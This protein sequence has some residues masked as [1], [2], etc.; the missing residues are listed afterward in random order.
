MKTRIL[1]AVL[2]SLLVVSVVSAAMPN[3]PAGRQLARVTPS[4]V[5]VAVPEQVVESSP[6]IEPVNSSGTHPT[7]VI[8]PTTSAIDKRNFRAKGCTILHELSD[9]TALACPK[10]VVIPG[11]RPDRLFSLHDL[12]AD[13]QIGADLVWAEG[14]YDGTGVLVAILDTGVDESHIELS[15]SIVATKNFV[16][17]RGVDKDG[18]GTHVS[19]IVTANG[20]YEIEGNYATGVA[21]GAA[22]IV[23]KVC[24]P[25]G[26]YESDIMAGIEWAV[27]QGASVLNL[28]IGGGNFCGE[29]CD[30]DPLA[31]KVNWAVSEGV[32][33]AISAGNEGDCVSSPACAS[34]A[35]AVGAT[36][37][38]DYAQDIDWVDCIDAAPQTDDRVCWS[39][40]GPALDLVAPGI[41][42]LSTYSCLA[43]GDCGSYWYAW[44][45]GTSMSAPHIAGTAALILQKNPGYTVQDVKNAF[46]STAVDLG[47]VGYDSLYGWG[48]VDAY[49]AVQWTAGPVDNPPTVNITAPL[50]GATVSGIVTISAEAADD[51]GVVQVDFYCDSILLETDTTSTYSI[52]WDSSAVSDGPHSL[53][54]TAIDTAA[55]T[56]SDS[57]SVTVDNYNDP[58]VADDQSV[59]TVEDTSVD[60]TL[61]AGDADGDSLTFTIVAD[62]CNGILTGSAPNVTYT[63]DPGFTGSDSFTFRAYD[64]QAYSNIATV[65]I[66]VNPAGPTMHVSDITIG[67]RKMGRN[68]QATAYVTVVDEFGSP[69]GGA[70]VTG[71]WTL[72]GGYLN[73]ASKPTDSEGKA[74]LISAK[75]K[76]TSGNI[77]TLTIT[78]VA[79]DGCTYDAE[80]NVETSGSVTVP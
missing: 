58:P 22:I 41:D 9:A 59:T 25:S 39:N 44:M 76:T 7:R 21:P 56:S 64:G 33:V 11:A 70:T 37:H 73:T 54:A 38:K 51:D 52:D 23:G 18:H 69:V 67:L 46:Y 10:G 55:Q 31:A 49:A 53:T 13:V 74:T 20:V 24:G 45:S 3:N 8:V 63:P 17:G 77:F 80:S 28:S 65:F 75:I 1:M 4:G 40:Y 2:V 32:V 29:D 47:D 79:K 12:E 27:S 36:Y 62:P 15:D 66:T 50:D 42:I 34:G 71:D 48:R 30:D 6:V 68:Y 60:I 72:N 61:T 43:A 19:G 5:E 57:I 14:G 26:C 16:R 35:I 78:G